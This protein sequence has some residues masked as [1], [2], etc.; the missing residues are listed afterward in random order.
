VYV[1]AQ[2]PAV[3]RPSEELKGFARVVLAPGQTR[4]VTVP[5]DARSLAYYDVA[6]AQWRADAGG[7]DILVGNSSAS[8]L[9]RGI[10]T[11]PTAL[12]TPP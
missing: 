5:L 8:I 1:H 10:L 9:L 3:P 11:L 2:H 7:Y 4:R 12:T 6:G